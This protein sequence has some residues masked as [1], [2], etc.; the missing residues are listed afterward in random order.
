MGGRWGIGVNRRFQVSSTHTH[1]HTVV[2]PYQKEH[3]W[4]ITL[5]EHLKQGNVNTRA[6]KQHYLLSC[7]LKDHRQVKYFLRLLCLHL[8]NRHN[9]HF[10]HRKR[11]CHHK[12]AFRSQWSR[13]GWVAWPPSPNWS[14]LDYASSSS[15]VHTAPLAI[16]CTCLNP[17]A[18]LECATSCWECLR[19]LPP[20]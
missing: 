9:E 16:S 20:Q 18:Q 6:Y 15:T 8:D 10:L 12:S 3:T 19:N 4:P 5:T 2:A 1:T 13:G 17:Y 14:T 11:I 7:N